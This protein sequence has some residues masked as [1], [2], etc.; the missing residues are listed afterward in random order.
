MKIEQFKLN[1]DIMVNYSLYIENC[2]EIKKISDSIDKFQEYKNSLLIK[3]DYDI[4]EIKIIDDSISIYKSSLVKLIDSNKKYTDLFFKY[5]IFPI[6]KLEEILLMLV[7]VYSDNHFYVTMD[8]NKFSIIKGIDCDDSL[9][10]GESSSYNIN[11]LDSKSIVCN[12]KFNYVSDFMSKFVEYRIS[13]KIDK[14]DDEI[15]YS[16]FKKYLLEEHMLIKLK[17]KKDFH[18]SVDQYLKNELKDKFI[19]KCYPSVMR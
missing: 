6:D 4:E 7:N 2:E 15:F 13:E 14:V 8:D 11:L 19:V 5:F 16:F 9:I 1:N 17:M 3:K 18:G 12:S 10:I